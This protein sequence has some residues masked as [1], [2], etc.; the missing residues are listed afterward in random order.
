MNIIITSTT[1]ATADSHEINLNAFAILS[2]DLYGVI[3]SFSTE[4]ET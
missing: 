3:L 1:P 2:S 4:A